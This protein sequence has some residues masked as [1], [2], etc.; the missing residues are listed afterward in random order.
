M[1]H[2][3]WIL[4]LGRVGRRGANLK[5]SVTKVTKYIEDCHVSRY[6]LSSSSTNFFPDANLSYPIL[7]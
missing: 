6:G 4:E 1:N 2:T 7:S 5:V 3:K